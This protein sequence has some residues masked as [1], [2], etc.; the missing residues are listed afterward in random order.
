MAQFFFNV[1]VPVAGAVVGK[2]LSVTATGGDT[3]PN[4]FTKHRVTGVSV[5]FGAG[6]PLVVAT[7]IG[8]GTG[9][10]TWRATGS[11]PAGTPAGA[12]V[13][14]TVIA[15]RSGMENHGTPTEP[16][17]VDVPQPDFTKQVQ[18]VTETQG[19][20]VGIDTFLQDVTPGTLPY[21][22]ALT[23]TATDVGSGIATVRVA[24]DGGAPVTAT[25]TSGDWAH[26]AATIPVGIGDHTVSATAVDNLGNTGMS[27][28][29]ITVKAPVEPTPVEQ[30]FAV[31]SYLREVLGMA[32]RYLRLAGAGTG[33][34]NLELADWLRQP[35][36]RLVAPVAFVP[37]TL[38]VAQARLAIEVLRKVLAT[39]APVQLDKRYRAQAYEVI[40]RELGSSSE[41][42]RLA[43]TAD[44]PTR[45]A[46]AQRLGITVD[47]V[48]PDR[49]D[50]ITLPPDE[51]T[52]AQL[53]QLFG[54]RSTNPSDPLVLPSAAAVGLWQQD[55]LKT[56]WRNA[57]AAARDRLD[58][59]LPIIDPDLLVEGHLRNAAATDLAR[60]LWTERRSWIQ[61]QLAAIAARFTGTGRTAA[62][63]DQAVRD[64]GLTVDLAAL[65]VRDK[66]G[67]DIS[68]ELGA[69]GLAVDAFRFLVR[70]RALL[71]GSTVTEV[72]W[73]YVVSILTQ[74]R[75]RGVFA[76]WRNEERQSGIVLEPGSFV[77]EAA[78]D[79]VAF[80]GVLRWRAT[81]STLATWRRTLLAREAQ[82]N[83]TAVG[84]RST[85]EAA[86]R[87]VLP[88]LRDALVAEAGLR[89]SPP[90]SPEQAAERLSR[91]FSIDL[92]AVAGTRTTRVTQAVDSLQSLLVSARSGQ[93]PDTGRAATV[94][95][96]PQFDLEWEWLATYSRWRAA[97]T[98][99]AYPENRLLPSLFVHENAGADRV[100][101]PTNAY[102]TFLYGTTGH[103]GLLG[104]SRLTPDEALTAAATY[105]AAVKSE[106]GTAANLGG[107]ELT[108]TRSDTELDAYR[109][110]CAQ[111]AAGPT[112][113]PFTS[114]RQILQ[115][116]REVFWLVPV[117]LARKLQDCG[118]YSAA[119]DWYQTV[120]AHQLPPNRR[121][122]YHGLSLEQ[123]TSSTFGR[124]PEWLPLVNE[125]NP[126]FTARH[127]KGAYTRFTTMS[128]VECFL[129]FADSEFA[130]NAPDS[131][132]RARA[133]YQTAAD[134]LGLP[135]LVPETGPGIPFPVN[136]VWQSLSARAAAGL[137]KIH[138]G[139][140]IAGQI[141]LTP[142]GSENVLPS[143]YRYSVLI[144][145]TKTLV[146]IA[147]QVESAY[148]SALERADGENYALLQA[149]HDLR[150]AGSSLIAQDLRVEAAVNGVAQAE[151]QRDRAQIQFGTYDEWISEGLNG[152]EWAGLGA[153]GWATGLQTAAAGVFFAGSTLD[154]VKGIFSFGLLGNAA[155]GLGQALQA[156][157][158]A[159]STGAQIAQ[160]KASFER[161][162]N[163]WRL[164]RNLAGKDVQL[165]E[166]QISG[167]QIQQ[168]IAAQERQ[169]SV[170]Q[171]DHAQAVAE[172]LAAKFT[173]ADL[174]EWMSGVLAGVYTFFLQQATSLALLAQAQLAFER[175]ETVGGFIA[176]DYW[177]PAADQPG[178]G[179]LSVDRRGITGSARLLQDVFRL[180]QHAFD[181]D[182][183]K[184]HLTQ[185]IA[186][187]EIAGFEL[188]QFR[189]T[190][191]LTFA[192]PQELFDRDFP[193]HYLRLIK[194]IRLST[195]ALLRPGRGLR[196]T[197]SASGVSRAV[198]SRDSFQNV[199]LRREPES[200]SFTA[201]I[202]ATGLFELEPDGSM[203]L[204]FEGMGVDTVWQLEIPKASNPFDF[205]SIVD[206]LFT[207][208]YTTLDSQAYRQQV[209]RSLDRS[210]TG[211]RSFS[212]R[213]QFPDAWFDLNN[214]ETVEDPARR[215]RIT[216][217]VT[218]ADLPAHIAGITL[219]QLTLFVVRDDELT[220]ELT[221]TA[222][223]YSTAGQT[224]E[225]GEARTVG[226]IIS[227]RRPGGAPWQGL[228]DADPVGDWELQLAD[229]PEVRS[230]FADGLIQDLVLVFTLTGTTPAWP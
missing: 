117:A 60:V 25:N 62:G 7:K 208:E 189:R 85:I 210:F 177:Q 193:G 127:R 69:A 129:A 192:T 181:T 68:A 72:E 179:G 15:H 111:L 116:H 201:P 228:V 26:W 70:I 89:A 132:A 118:H 27:Q 113:N 209:I 14:L 217:P 11:L 172:F 139:L 39:P 133:L 3:S 182:R 17:P 19:P 51:I 21:Q 178:T 103:P 219:A 187:S 138:A 52:D 185:T 84:Q 158:G 58:A 41:E 130:G 96:E 162:E 88:L 141:D 145:R 157:A 170:D 35:L 75:K 40:L 30:A 197:L 106:L 108:N 123:N 34:S 122:I 79:P 94:Q 114:E 2:T 8:T 48:R 42:L 140:N 28:A 188:Q 137:A 203:L 80:I 223:R 222:A 168:R 206:V 67:E 95:N 107:V 29:L 180:D 153:L 13:T 221:I 110:L 125:L 54:Y 202:G 109:T 214:P 37:A 184:L 23:G 47:T 57:D 121:F 102:G 65:S 100:L 163:E 149:G 225:A 71:T 104:R 134:L 12:S 36:D 81:W 115:Q 135:V 120:F 38:E 200:I 44:A 147:Q 143:L 64:S 63:F 204:P 155:G 216:L 191:V 207:V 212:V 167:A 175:Q 215:M 176:A 18:V 160:A 227:T 161:R 53:E 59:P 136:P 165:A 186:L 190:G 10:T 97:M 156:M 74:V 198:V 56:L 50:A 4:T 78:D 22:L 43:A 128:I 199:T 126:H 154:L 91:D 105:L 32:R 5:R 87:E 173:N 93:L 146:G 101:A 16:N 33:P 159:A 61:S 196:A 224:T 151:L 183:R 194:R 226:G 66:A 55:A 6:G 131:N 77:A 92:R 49:L 73:T 150:V 1:S 148:L 166:N 76:G 195:V 90:R 205:N 171:L 213:N 45:Q 86:E 174:Y 119:L 229:T 220:D 218:A 9:S 99:F 31:T 83:T 164:N 24:L 82:A 144:E 169:I 230:W 112:N 142:T 124:L 20:Q 152:Y 98:A 46:L 211:D